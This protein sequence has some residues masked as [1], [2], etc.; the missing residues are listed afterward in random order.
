VA[1]QLPKIPKA[2]RRHKDFKGRRGKKIGLKARIYKIAT[3]P[4]CLKR[5]QREVG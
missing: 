2:Q 4:G 1:E 5:R 3:Y